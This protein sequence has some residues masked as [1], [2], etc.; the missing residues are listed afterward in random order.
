MT[1]DQIRKIAAECGARIDDMYLTVYPPKPK[2][3]QAIFT[4][5][6]L[7]AFAHAIEKQAKREV[8]EEAVT[9]CD[10]FIQDTTGLSKASLIRRDSDTVS[11]VREMLKELD[12]A[13]RD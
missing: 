8:L 13:S 10:G 5:D 4:E 12:G 2:M 11:L 7:I 3:A 6:A 9:I 1:P